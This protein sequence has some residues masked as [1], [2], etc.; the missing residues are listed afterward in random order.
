MTQASVFAAIASSDPQQTAG[1]G[2]GPG[3]ADAPGGTG[4]AA[5]ASGADI[6]TFNLSKGGL[7]AIVVVVVIV[8]IFG[9]KLR[10]LARIVR[11]SL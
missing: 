6:S 9:S 10:I 1:E 5:G 11:I 3:E 2:G 7:A 8:V 4:N